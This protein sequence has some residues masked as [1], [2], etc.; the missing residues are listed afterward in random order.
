MN[1]R[2]FI[3]NNVWYVFT[4]AVIPFLARVTAYHIQVFVFGM[5]PCPRKSAVT[6]NLNFDFLNFTEN[7]V[8]TGRFFEPF[9]VSR[10]D[11]L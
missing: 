4:F 2:F 11:A 10:F 9:K 3:E 8:T 5:I 1:V 7:Y 6:K